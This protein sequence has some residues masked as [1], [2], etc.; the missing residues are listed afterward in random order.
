MTPAAKA[1]LAKTIAR[2]VGFDLAG[3]V[4]ARP[5]PRASNYREWLAAGYAGEMTYLHRNVRF[6]EDP[7]RLLPDARSILCVGL[8][9]RREDGFVRRSELESGARTEQG[10]PSHGL[11]AQYARGRD[12]HRV[13]HAML[14]DLLERLRARLS[15]DFAACAFVDTGPVLERALAAEAGLG[16]IGRNTCLLNAQLGSYVFL[17]ELIT[18]LDLAA[19]ELVAERC[20]SCTRCVDACPTQA[21]VAPYRLD[22]RRCLSYLTIEHRGEI[23]E[24]LHGALGPRVFGCDVCQQVCPYNARGPRA[25]HPEIA[26]DVLGARVDLAALLTWSDADFKQRLSDSAGARAR[27]EMWRRNAALVLRS[28]GLRAQGP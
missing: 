21:L 3:V 24:E 2:E 12:Y 4:H 10:R 11:I 13:L 17:G 18:T 25:T 6:R 15:E 1:L 16:W 28:A 9:Y 23:A 27:P 20:G 8:N 14:A 22:A 5:L 7:G 26:C 19:D